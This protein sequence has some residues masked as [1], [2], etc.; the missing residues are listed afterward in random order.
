MD[1]RLIFRPH[2]QQLPVMV[3]RV[4]SLL[5]ICETASIKGGREDLVR[6]GET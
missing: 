3:R 4:V 1:R 6:S 2:L 5:A